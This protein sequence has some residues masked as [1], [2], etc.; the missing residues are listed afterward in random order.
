MDDRTKILPYYLSPGDAH[1]SV[2]VIGSFMI[3]DGVKINVQRETA[4]KLV[5]TAQQIRKA[6][7]LAWTYESIYYELRDGYWQGAFYN[8]VSSEAEYGLRKETCCK[9]TVHMAN[10]E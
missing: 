7:T 8:G 3:V 6:F 9:M 5:N 2:V 4:Y 10:Y 1:H